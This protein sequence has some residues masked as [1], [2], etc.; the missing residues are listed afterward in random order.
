MENNVMLKIEGHEVT[1]KDV[2]DFLQT[3]G[4]EAMQFNNEEGKKQIAT[5]LM[6]QHLL[7]LDA[8]ESGLEND[9]EFVKELETAKEQILRQYS[10]KKVLESVRV[11]EEEVK[12]YYEANKSRFKP[13]YRFSAKHILV[14]D[15]Q[16]ANDLKKQID[17]GASFEE[18]AQQKS[19]CPSSQNG[20]D[21]GMFSTGQMV[22]E[23]EK[24]CEL[25]EVGQISE[26][27]KTQFGYHII[28]LEDKALARDADLE[29]NKHDIEGMLL[30]MKQQEAYLNKTTDL[31]DKYKVEKSF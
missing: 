23:F 1:E 27:V 24:A 22:P 11:T 4:Q 30:G 2:M 7:Y 28:K 3:L 10:M 14:D 25:L 15:E 13:I 20:G 12:E 31:Q 17:E 9:E 19:T 8:K 16:L 18:V 21:L 29:S 6:N 26:P 5:E